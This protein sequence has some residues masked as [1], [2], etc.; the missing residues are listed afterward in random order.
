MDEGRNRPSTGSASAKCRKFSVTNRFFAP[1]S[2]SPMPGNP[3]CPLCGRRLFAHEKSRGERK[4]RKL[5]T[6]TLLASSLLVAGGASMV[7][8][9][10]EV[11][12]NRGNSGDPES[13]DPH[14][15]STV[16]EAHIL[17]DLFEG[18]VMQDK[19]AN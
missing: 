5:L 7:P 3:L 17:R 14:K 4:M 18:L 1:A 12:Y 9:F 2:R 15:T 11:V 6:A 8:A 13:L 10:A 16:N 19:D